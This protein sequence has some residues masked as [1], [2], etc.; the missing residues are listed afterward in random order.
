V[1]FFNRTRF[2]NLLRLLFF[3]QA[4]TGTA[5]LKVVYRGYS[6]SAQ[7]Q[8]MHEEAIVRRTKLRLESDAAKEEQ[9]TRTMELQC[10]EQRSAKERE[11]EEKATRHKLAMSAL[12][13]EQERK[14]SD[15]AHSLQLRHEADKAAALLAQDRDRHAEELRHSADRAAE[16]MKQLR[17]RLDVEM[18][19]NN[20]IAKLEVD[21]TKYLTAFAEPRPD[22]H[23]R[24][25]TES[26][27]N[28]HLSLP[29]PAPSRP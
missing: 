2:S 4:Q 11:L 3:A 16:E 14:Q 28:L 8:Q 24:I 22:Q 25:D 23:V 1:H 19:R 21:M 29:T 18:G 7:L 6:T 27:P 17:E 13:K 15:E 20:A 10:R 26:S 9:E 5:L 12:S